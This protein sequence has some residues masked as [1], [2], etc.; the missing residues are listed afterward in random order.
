MSWICQDFAMLSHMS[1]EVSSWS[2]LSSLSCLFLICI[3]ISWW[4]SGEW[5]EPSSTQLKN[6]CGDPSG[7]GSSNFKSFFAF[8]VDKSESA[9]DLNAET[10]LCSLFLNFLLGVSSNA[11]FWTSASWFAKTGWSF[12]YGSFYMYSTTW[13]CVGFSMTVYGLSI[14]GTWIIC[15]AFAGFFLIICASM[16]FWFLGYTFVLRSPADFDLEPRTWL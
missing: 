9:V 12:G 10:C 15:P 14:A 11:G 3:S 8:G 1:D 7:I 5:A 6:L 16:Y 4:V 2:S 13:V